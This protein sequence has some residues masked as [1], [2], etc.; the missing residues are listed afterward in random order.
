MDLLMMILS[1]PGV[2]LSLSGAFGGVAR[3]LMIIIMDKKMAIRQG[4]AT[5]FLGGIVGFF[6]T[7]QAGPGIG[8]AFEFVFRSPPDP[9]KAP[10]FNAFL[11]G[12]LAV[13]V[14]GF[15]IDTFAT[16]TKRKLAVDEPVP[17]PPKPVDG[18]S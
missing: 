4:I 17:T 13:A 10:I 8:A 18:G 7:P 16:W 15:A 6:V 5:V 3:W 9:E 14:I 2:H 12:V 1:A 11:L